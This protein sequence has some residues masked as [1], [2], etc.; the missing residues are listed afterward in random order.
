MTSSSPTM[1]RASSQTSW[2]WK[3]VCKSG[4]VELRILL[5]WDLSSWWSCFIAGRIRECVSGVEA[6]SVNV[7]RDG[8]TLPFM[9]GAGVLLVVL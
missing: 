9:V 1:C 2:F 3:R 6:A 8:P 5:L 4:F 7:R